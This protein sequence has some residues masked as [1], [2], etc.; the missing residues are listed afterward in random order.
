VSVR[1]AGNGAVAGRLHIVDAE[2]RQSRIVQSD[3]TA[4]RWSKVNSSATT[5]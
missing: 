1:Y 5:T 3:L 2:T 4:V